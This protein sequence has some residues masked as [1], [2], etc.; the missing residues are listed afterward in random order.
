MGVCACT[1]VMVSI[2]NSPGITMLFI[3]ICLFLLKIISHPHLEHLSGRYFLFV[4]CVKE[5]LEVPLQLTGYLIFLFQT[6]Q[7]AWLPGASVLQL[8]NIIELCH[9]GL[10]IAA[11][12]IV[13]LLYFPVHI[14]TQANSLTAEL[15]VAP[16]GSKADIIR[17]AGAYT[18]FVVYFISDR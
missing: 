9:V 5:Q 14:A 15:H 16:A 18:G 13:C 1:F 4:Q 12:D 3:W 2:K 11:H 10:F 8:G 17:Y 7:C 6:D